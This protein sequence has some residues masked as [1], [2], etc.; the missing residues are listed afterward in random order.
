AVGRS[1]GSRLARACIDRGGFGRWLRGAGGCG[2]GGGGR[3]SRGRG[4]R[5]GGRGGWGDEAPGRV[6]ADLV[7][8]DIDRRGR[9]ARAASAPL[10]TVN[11][12]VGGAKQVEP[13]R[14]VHP[15]RAVLPREE[16]PVGA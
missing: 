14:G 7:E 1:G 10:P 13:E 15:V 12:A 4:R 8:R 9:A 16:R 2:G 5:G 11:V 3:R 6:A